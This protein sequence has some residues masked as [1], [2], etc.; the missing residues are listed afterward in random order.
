M[1][2]KGKTCY[3]ALLIVFI[4]CCSQGVSLST[5]GES[6]VEDSFT[7]RFMC[8]LN[9][10][11]GD[12]SSENEECFEHDERDIVS[13]K[14]IKEQE[15]GLN[16][17]RISSWEEEISSAPKEDKIRAGSTSEGRI[18]KTG[19]KNNCAMVFADPSLLRFAVR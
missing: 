15:S 3:C 16:T 14:F 10:E 12:N 11:I 8:P 9:D 13:E 6:S 7:K 1:A 2:R 18:Q 4:C 19:M 17:E 5:A